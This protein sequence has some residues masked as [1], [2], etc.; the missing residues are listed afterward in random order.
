MNDYLFGQ[1]LYE[2]R[3]KAGCSQ[4]ELAE[5]LG[6]TNKAVSKWETGASKTSVDTI[7]KLSALFNIS[8]EELFSLRDSEKTKEVVKIIITGGPCAGKS[9]AMSRIQSYFT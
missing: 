5:K 8:V 9:T 7:R 4:A 6:V 2:Y 3:K 1:K